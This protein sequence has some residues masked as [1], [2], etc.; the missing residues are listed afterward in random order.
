MVTN[1]LPSQHAF[2]PASRPRGGRE[3]VRGAGENY[4]FTGW[5][6][7]ED[8]RDSIELVKID[9]S[10]N[11]KHALLFGSEADDQVATM[12]PFGTGCVIVGETGTAAGWDGF[13]AN[14]TADLKLR[15]ARL[16]GGPR[17]DTAQAVSRFGT[18]YLLAGLTTPAGDRTA[19]SSYV[20]T[21]VLTAGTARGHA[22]DLFP[23]IGDGGLKKLVQ[24][25]NRAYLLAHA[26]KETA[27]SLVCGV[28]PTGSIDWVRRLDL[29]RAHR[30][31]D[32]VRATDYAARLLLCGRQLEE[33]GDTA[34]LL[35]RTDLDLGSCRTLDEKTPDIEPLEFEV[36]EWQPPITNLEGFRNVDPGVWAQSVTSRTISICRPTI[37]IEHGEQTHVQSPYLYLQAVGSDASD[38]SARG[39]HLRWELQRG[40]GERHLPKGDLA[41]PGGPFPASLDFDRKDDYVHIYRS[42]IG[43]VNL[44][45][46]DFR[47][48]P[49]EL[50][51]DGTTQRWRY[52]FEHPAEVGGE[53]EIAVHFAD[54]GRYDAVRA[55]IDPGARPAELVAKYGGV[56][57]LKVAGKLVFEVGLRGF[58]PQAA[59]ARLRLETV[60]L[61]DPLDPDSRLVSCR[62]ELLSADLPEASTLA[63]NVDTLRLEARGVTSGIVELHTYVDT[64]AA[65]NARHGGWSELGAF[66][67]TADDAE[68]Y[69]RLESTGQDPVDG[70]WPRFNEPD[71]ATG[72]FTVR[73]A[74]YRDKWLPAGEPEDGIKEAVRQYLDRSRSDEKAPASL[75]S[76]QEGD[77]VQLDV[78]YLDMLRLIAADF[79]IARM[80][81]LGHLD[82][83]GPE[84]ADRRFLYLAE[85]VTDGALEPGE[86]SGRTH[87]LAMSLP[88]GQSNHRLPAP[89]VLRSPSY[90]LTVDNATPSPTVLTLEGG[91]DRFADVRY[92]NLHKEPAQE[93][94]PV[95][96]FFADPEPSCL[97]EETPPVLFGVESVRG[98]LPPPRD[99][100]RPRLPGRCRARRGG[101]AAAGDRRPAAAGVRTPGRGA[102]RPCVRALRHQL[103]FAGFAP[104]RDGGD[105]QHGLSQARRSGGAPQL[106]G[107]AHPERATPDL[108]HAARAG[109]ALGAG[110]RPD[111]GAGDLR[112]EPRPSPSI[113][114]RRPCRALFSGAPAARRSR[115]GGGRWRCCPMAG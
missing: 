54:A 80:L 28:Q 76:G 12:L 45:R 94:R 33:G 29:D 111:P 74:N 16:V 108:H 72:A 69:R 97:A 8:K 103:V 27:H 15:W 73:I 31:L 56:L 66:A 23:G 82:G 61:P 26:S 49:E 110:G 10:G 93:G 13:I 38:G 109:D 102:G 42:E 96:D 19:S 11:V 59:D 114:V 24:R 107:P 48:A 64:I 78:S 47:Q 90:G 32:I 75:P 5:H 68:A 41:A 62:R 52:R 36:R 92:V 89:P 105:R 115:H 84:L 71:P 99:R 9:G 34:A 6:E 60:S 1:L 7:L 65:H 4:F 50:S 17:L 91:Y 43:P 53:T 21:F 20:V 100:P 88:T 86:P 40:L 25:G 18:R 63:E 85:Y 57:E 98:R 112:L 44:A 113:S 30:V 14:F 70:R 37:P 2:H 95:A 3:L 67:L 58:T 79:H 77:A 104:E 87:H 83:Q 51:E 39:A 35:A 55:E 22:F 106:H 46:L 81:G 101:G